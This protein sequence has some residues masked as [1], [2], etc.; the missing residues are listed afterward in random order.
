MRPKK[1]GLDYFPL[2]VRFYRSRRVRALSARH[3]INAL[4]V[5]SVLLCRIYEEGYYIKFDDLELSVV[6]ADINLP[7]AE[8]LQIVESAVQLGLFD[9]ECYEQHKVLTSKS[10]QEQ[11]SLCTNRRK[12]NTNLLEYWLLSTE[13]PVSGVSVDSVS[14]KTPKI[15]ES[16]I[17]ESKVKE[18]KKGGS[19]KPSFEELPEW[20]N[21]SER[22]KTEF[23]RFVQY[24]IERKPKLKELSKCELVKKY[25]LA[26]EMFAA[27][28]SKTIENGWQ[29]L[30]EPRNGQRVGKGTPSAFDEHSEAL[31]RLKNG[32]ALEA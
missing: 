13:T 20:E 5:W 9:S 4:T 16:K 28:V 27:M 8:L 25:H 24:R 31:R 26:P 1:K 15:K 23:E 32:E 30:H 29:G 18:S 22:F 19:G 14:T 10:I 12:C 2:E 11:Y 7:E 21:A 3:G 17:K 6:S